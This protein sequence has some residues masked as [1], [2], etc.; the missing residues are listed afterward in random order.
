MNTQVYT[1]ACTEAGF[2]FDIISCWENA[3]EDGL[4]R[5]MGKL[6]INPLSMDLEMMWDDKKLYV[7]SLYGTLCFTVEYFPATIISVSVEIPENEEGFTYGYCATYDK[8]SWGF[9]SCVA[10]AL[11]DFVEINEL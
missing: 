3:Y 1:E 6:H 11:R 9:G 4:E 5:L 7:D 8:D 10:A 2:V